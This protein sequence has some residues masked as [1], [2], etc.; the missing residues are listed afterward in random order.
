MYRFLGAGHETTSTLLT[1]TL[2]IL[3]QNERVVKKLR[4]EIATV[5]GD[6]NEFGIGEL[7]KLTYMS[8]VFKEVF[9]MFPPVSIVAR[10]TTC[11]TKLG[12]YTL[13][14]KVY[15]VYYNKIIGY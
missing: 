15:F 6:S 4:E 14:A 12:E 13:P 2:Y 3:S 11:E 10:R 9:R 8:H 7:E 1:W 5:M